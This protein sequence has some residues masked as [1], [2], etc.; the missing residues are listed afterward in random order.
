M[1]PVLVLAVLLTA[2]LP[3]AASAQERGAPAPPAPPLMDGQ[4]SGLRSGF[5]LKPETE[6]AA[7]ASEARMRTLEQRSA[8]R[9]RQATGSICGGCSGT[10][11]AVRSHG[12]RVEA[13][14]GSRHRD[15]IA[16]HDPAQARMD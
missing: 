14:R 7:A 15:D 5:Y 6:V 8:K 1:R 4:R 16:I 12:M 9:V 3:A 2:L 11:D 13:A 10:R